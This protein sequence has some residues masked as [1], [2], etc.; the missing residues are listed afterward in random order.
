M[1]YTYF[2]L[3]IIF[4]FNFTAYSQIGPGGINN[5]NV[6]WVKA[7]Y[8]AIINTG[9]VTDWNDNSSGLNNATQPNATYQPTYTAVHKNYNP[10]IYFDGND[11]HLNINDLIDP[12]SQS[13]T[14]FAVGTNEGG[15][16][17]WHAMVSGQSDSQWTSGGYGLCSFQGQADFG[18]WTNQWTTNANS[19]WIGG[20]NMASSIL[21]GSY[22]SGTIKFYRN[23]TLFSQ[24]ITTG[25]IGDGGSTHLGG[26]VA[27]ANS[28]KGYIS[29]VII[30]NT[31]LNDTDRT[32][33]NSYL[34]IKYAITINRYLSNDNYYASNGNS[35]YT[36]NGTNEYWRGIIGIARDDNSELY[37]KQSREKNGNTKIYL[38]TLESS[39]QNNT[40][41]FSSN[42]QFVVVGHNGDLISVTDS[43]N[44]E[45]PN[46]VFSRIEREWK[47]TNTNFPDQFNL[48][49]KLNT[50]VEIPS[51][52]AADLRLLIDLDGDFSDATIYNSESG[53]NMSVS[54][55]IITISGLSTSFFPT[56]ESRFFTIA[57]IND[58]TLEDNF[59]ALP[60]ND[61]YGCEENNSGYAT[62]TIDLTDIEN[63]VIGTQ[64]D[65]TVSYFDTNYNP[66]NLT[67]NYTNSTINQETII[68][69][70]TNSIGCYD[71]T[72]FNLIVQTRPVV[73]SVTDVIA[74]PEYILP[75]LTNGNY[76]TQSGGTGNTL[77]AGD[78]I[79][80]SQTLYVYTDNGTCNNESSF[81]VT[82]NTLPTVSTLNDQISCGSFILPPIT[83]GNYFTETGGN[84]T[85]LFSGDTIN[86]SQTIYIYNGN[87]LC[88]NESFFNVTI[89]PLPN[90]SILDDIQSCVTYELPEIVSGNYFSEPYGNGTMLNAGDIIDTTQT[91]YIYI[92]DGN[93][94]NQ[95]SFNITINPLPTVVELNDVSE[96]G[97]YILPNIEN[98]NYFTEPDGN[99]IS[100]NPGD[101][102]VTSQTIYL[103]YDDGN[104]T[105]ES[106]FYVEI[107]PIPYIVF[108][109]ENIII[110]QQDITVEIPTNTNAQFLYKLD[111]DSYQEEN[112]FFD[113]EPGDHTIY[114]TDN[115]GCFEESVNF[116]IR[117]LQVP[118]FFTPN[119]DGIND[120]W[121]VIDSD[122]NIKSIEIFDRY[123]RIL[124]RLDKNSDGW[125]GN[126]KG[127][128]LQNT[129][130]WYVIKFNNEP[131]IK[132]HFSLITK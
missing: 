54:G 106:S 42:N 102:I 24:N 9:L 20:N 6:F 96:C 39:N 57:S 92:D 55:N 128:L 85:P 58:I 30:Y 60:V 22:D 37:Q 53:M 80:T 11:K 82:I 97:Q 41:S 116:R 104:C 47:L 40:G 14:V 8:G 127:K 18:F 122:D 15:G 107:I 5:N 68:V 100:L 74:C 62:F 35:I 32:K 31:I 43:A 34:G 126:W 27:T 88:S 131:S 118:D 26:G 111:N 46:G 95:S 17:Y 4:F 109:S 73:D 48:Q 132:G 89:N 61:I 16:D 79:S 77:F 81:N 45:K 123:G 125:D 69:R 51:I 64:T 7:D 67:T 13:V 70:V 12:N 93:C 90:V 101:S 75:P 52:N 86:S 1:K 98:G 108:S 130:Y 76:Y 28:H 71:E 78:T 124:K 50:C 2:I 83:D 66:I 36:G 84:G 114:I 49:I 65:L 56:N 105:N 38:N 115:N 110:N 87:N 117:I 129:D 121:K 44:N 91:L 21:E 33:I 103:F 72:T 25:S 59:S 112:Q 63:Q 113:L 19:T 94:T 99:G 10:S 29:E 23:A 120:Y 119:N 3:S